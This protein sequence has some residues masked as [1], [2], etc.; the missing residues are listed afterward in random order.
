MRKRRIMV[1]GAERCGKTSLVNL[2]NG[3]DE[4]PKRRQDIIFTDKTIDV[5]AAY[6]ENRYYNKHVVTISQDAS[7]VLVLVNQSDPKIVYSHGFVNALMCDNKLGVITYAD[8]DIQN[9]KKCEEQ[10]KSCDLQPPFFNINA[11]NKL[12]IDELKQHLK[13]LGII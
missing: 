10:L 11:K 9:R 2:I 1:I 5:P 7:C 8:R 12:G 6:L 3:I 4:P 13:T